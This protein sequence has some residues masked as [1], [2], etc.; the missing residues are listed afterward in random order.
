M[1]RWAWSGAAGVFGGFVGNGVLGLL[2]SSDLVRGVLYD[3]SI[4]SALF[5]EI[6]PQ[7]NIPVSVAG[8]VVLSVVHGWLYARLAPAMPGGGWWQK[9]LYWG[10]ALWALYWLPQEWFVY[11]TLLGE[12]L[13]LNLVELTLLLAGSVVEGVVIARCL[14]RDYAQR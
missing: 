1:M 13:L 2:F 5:L 8:L 9:G 4:Q 12:P 7:R 10:V 14:T 11:H 3:P 6:T